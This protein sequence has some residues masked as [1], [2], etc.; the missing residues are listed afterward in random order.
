M[1]DELY[2]ER[3][4]ALARSKAGAG[5]MGAPDATARR[6]NPLCGDR[7]T[8]DL[9]LAADGSVVELMHQVRGCLLCQAS[10]AALAGVAVGWR[11]EHAKALRE[12]VEVL[13]KTGETDGVPAPFD[14]FAPVQ[15]HP[16]RH[17]CVTLAVDALVDAL[18]ASA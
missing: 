8:L 6:D 5:K 15:K 1:A 3:I 12:K 10:A 13:L 4:V 9:R 17:D 16:S 18:A 7:A 2:H 11:A 14:A